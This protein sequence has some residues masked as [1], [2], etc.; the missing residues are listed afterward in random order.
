MKNF[1]QSYI[2]RFHRFDDGVLQSIEV[3]YET[4]GTKKLIVLLDCQDLLDVDAGWRSVRIVLHNLF[5][6][7][8]SETERTS[9]Q[10]LSSGIHVI[11]VGGSVGIEL[12]DLID[13]PKVLDELRRSSLF[14]IGEKITIEVLN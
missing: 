14:G 3:S 5:E 6:Y 2:D 9:A 7:R 10:V 12:G 1:N 11:E 4:F 8:F 13:A